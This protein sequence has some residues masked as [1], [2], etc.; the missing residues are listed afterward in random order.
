M[1]TMLQDIRYALRQ[2]RKSPGFTLTVTLTLALG[3][4]A[5]TAMFSIIRAVLLKP[6]PFRDPA[7]LVL[8]RC[9]MGGALNPMVS[10]PDYY[11]YREQANDF[12]G[13][14]AVLPIP[15]KATITGDA[16]PERVT[17][18]Y[19]AHDL[20]QT[21]GV[22]PTAGRWFTAGEGKPGAPNVVIVSE[23]FARR[24][25][26]TP[27]KA[28]GTSFQING[29]S[30]EVVGVMPAS[31]HFLDDFDAWAPMRR[32]DS[33]AGAPRQFHNWL[34]VGRLK[35]G[36]TRDGAQRQLDVISK[37]LEQQYP[38]SNAGKALQVDPL[39]AALAER[40]TPQL[41][42]LMAAV[43][44]VLLIACANVA[45]LLLAR[46]SAR[47][48]ELAMR[49][50]LG[51][52][53]VRIAKQLLVESVTLA[54]LSSILGVAL[55]FWLQRVLP[56]LVRL[57]D[58][59]SATPSMDWQVLLFALALSILT[60]VLFGVAPALR[61]SSSQLIQDLAAGTRTTGT[62]TRM[63]LRSAL[64]V[65]QVAVSLM[66]LIGAGLLIRSFMHL[67]RTDP[68]FEVQ[69]LLTGEVQLP[70]AQYSD[71]NKRIQF[72]DSLREDLA[73]M[74]SVKAVGF[75]N[76]LPIRNPGNDVP[77]WDSDHP[78]EKLAYLRTAHRRI[79][80]PG[81]FDA[82]HVPIRSGRD[83]GKNDHENAPLT[84]V[85]NEQMARTLFA[86]RNPL[87]RRVSVDMGGPQPITFVVVGVVG[88]VR[89]NFVGDSAPQTMYLSYYQ[90]PDTT[91]RFA[92]RT[93][94]D[95]ELITQNVRRLALAHDR[96]VPV[97][98]LVSM[99]NLV[100]DSLVPQR[101]TAAILALFATV[102]LMLA[103][104]GLY[105]GLAYSVSQRTHEI[106]VR[107]ALGANRHEV[108]RLV[109]KQGMT[110]VIA[111]LTVGMVA[112]FGLT[113]LLGNMLFGIP[114]ND[115][116]TFVAVSVLLASVAALA[117]LLPARRAAS[118]E[119]MQALRSE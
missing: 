73:A 114:P 39:Q 46:G 61:G 50:A 67:A 24:R 71:R 42:L 1:N 80:M 76:Q 9:T 100:G 65:G 64:V 90:F 113:R 40:R 118:I 17:F 55:A 57:N 101:M 10:A 16:E 34:I 19:I 99:E 92:I 58:P 106:G 109:L 33:W 53:R 93:D 2:L 111:G 6:L 45:G 18:T 21:L 26:G 4:G 13:F 49:A 88:D 28:V 117:C 3:I 79:V 66:L 78:P 116:A 68:G 29:T 108:L 14:S 83:F 15:Q 74:H 35:P 95:P 23:R 110:L 41:F 43:S 94:Q 59:T 7:R 38:A 105:G 107:M 82:V 96:N 25:F 75:I 77:A 115:P 20:F 72:F 98:N 37:R 36:V 22:N 87:G 102:A 112:A 44:L 86:D 81:Y 119:P 11:D 27:G 84:M 91:L 32:G 54:M 47:R 89:L 85:I 62:K 30:Y 51:A 104:I 52:S 5:N 56:M 69:R 12:E 31:F 97:E 103:C 63:L 70:T 60:G 48:P 8:A